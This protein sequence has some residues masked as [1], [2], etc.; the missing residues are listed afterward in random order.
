L[1]EILQ[2]HRTEALAALDALVNLR[3]SHALEVHRI[4]PALATCRWPWRCAENVL[5]EQPGHTAAAE[6]R[7]IYAILRD[8]AE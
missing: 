5:E 4:A 2:D 1:R 7:R 6:R 8:L 3:R